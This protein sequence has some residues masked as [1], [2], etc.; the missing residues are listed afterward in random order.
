MRCHCLQHLIVNVSIFHFYFCLISRSKNVSSSQIRPG[1]TINRTF[2]H[3]SIGKSA[4]SM[5]RAGDCWHRC[6]VKFLHPTVW[7]GHM[8]WKNFINITQYDRVMRRTRRDEIQFI[9]KREESVCLHEPSGVWLGGSGSH[10][11]FWDEEGQQK[12]GRNNL[13]PSTHKVERNASY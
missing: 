4:H 1:A 12:R 5:S 11:H 10:H 6:N 13:N 7:Q 8:R 2:N 3:D 9:M